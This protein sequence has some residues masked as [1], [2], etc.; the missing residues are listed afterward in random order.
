MAQDAPA[1][2]PQPCGGGPGD[3][4]D[5]LLPRAAR[6]RALRLQWGLVGGLLAALAVIATLYLRG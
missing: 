4:L 3:P 6:S 5:T 1:T 2:Q